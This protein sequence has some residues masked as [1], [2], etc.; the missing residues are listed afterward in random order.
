MSFA[1]L[2][3]SDLTTTLGL[4]VLHKGK[5]VF[6][7]YPRMKEYEKPI[8]WSVTKVM[9]AMLVR[10]LEERGVVDVEKEVDY[11]IPELAASDFAG[12]KIRHI[13]DMSTGLDCQDEYQDRQSCYYQYSM[14]IGDGFREES[15]PDTVS[16]TH[17]TLPTKRIV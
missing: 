3:Q 7:S 6:E 15:S 17:L 4:L 11:Y 12:I 1:S 2:L 9:P 14:S 5:I 16:Y 13:L 10:L 8:Y